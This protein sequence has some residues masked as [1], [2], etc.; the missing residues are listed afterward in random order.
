MLTRPVGSA[1]ALCRRL[2]RD[3]ADCVNLPVLA[4]RNFPAEEALIGLLASAVHVDAV[5]F[6]SPTAVRACFR[7]CPQFRAPGWVFAQGPAT[8]RALLRKGLP[9]IQ[10]EQGY[11]SE[12][13]LLHPYFDAVAGKR[14]LRLSGQGGRDLLVSQLRARGCDASVIALYRRVP[15]R[16]QKRQLDLI[17]TLVDPILVV[18]S[19]EALQVLVQRCVPEQWARIRRW[20]ILVCSSRLE[21]AAY[22]QGFRRIHLA[23]SAAS[24]DLRAGL[25][26]L[27]EA[28]QGR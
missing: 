11:T 1:K 27:A 26:A 3:G 18:T 2:E 28:S 5:V 4:I 21:A 7:L 14:V 20:R 15:A 23:R 8:A 6:A 24:A 17:D 10:P 16:W 22:Q 12:D 25:L 19:A 9:S 13:L